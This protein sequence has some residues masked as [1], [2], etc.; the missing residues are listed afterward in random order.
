MYISPLDEAIAELERTD[1]TFIEEVR[2]RLKPLIGRFVSTAEP[3][4]SDR[5]TDGLLTPPCYMTDLELRKVAVDLA[6]LALQRG[7]D[8]NFA[9][10]ANGNTFLHKCVLLRDPKIA[11]EGVAWLLAH[12]ADPN[13]KRDDGQTPI[14]LAVSFDRAEVAKLMRGRPTV[15]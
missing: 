3:S 10:E 4:N 5:P 9:C 12:G 14:S 6:E 13:R 15:T 8:V 2:K 7:V 1:P 11:M